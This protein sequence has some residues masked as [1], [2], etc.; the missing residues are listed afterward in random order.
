MINMYV[1]PINILKGGGFS[2]QIDNFLLQFPLRIL[3]S[4]FE[5]G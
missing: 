4:I 1:H 2:P 3:K 5:Y